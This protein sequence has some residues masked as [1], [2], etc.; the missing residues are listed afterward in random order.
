MNNDFER[1]ASIVVV[2]EEEKKRRAFGWK[3]ERRW[4]KREKMNGR[5]GLESGLCL[6]G[7]EEEKKDAREIRW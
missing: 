3:M 7:K 2:D 4:Q 1:R 6:M 5:K